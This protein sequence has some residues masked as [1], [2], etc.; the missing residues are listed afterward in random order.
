MADFKLYYDAY[1]YGPYEYEYDYSYVKVRFTNDPSNPTEEAGHTWTEW[2]PTSYQNYPDNQFIR[3]EIVGDLLYLPEDSTGIFRKL[4]A[5]DGSKIAITHYNDRRTGWFDTL[6]VDLSNVRTDYVKNLSYAFYGAQ[7]WEISGLEEWY[8]ENVED[9]S[10]MFAKMPNGVPC[11]KSSTLTPLPQPKGKC[12]WTVLWGSSVDCCFAQYDSEDV[13]WD[14][15]YK[16][17]HRISNTSHWVMPKLK[18]MEG[19]FD[20]SY[21]I[22]YD[23]IKQMKTWKIGPCSNFSRAFA[24]AGQKVFTKEGSDKLDIDLSN[25]IAAT[26]DVNCKQMFYRLNNY[27]TISLPKTFSNPQIFSDVDSMFFNNLNISNIYVDGD[28]DWSENQTILDTT[29]GYQMFYNCKSISTFDNTKT[30]VFKANTTDGY[31]NTINVYDLAD[32]Y[33]RLPS[34]WRVSTPYIKTEDGWKESEVYW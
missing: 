19:L 24:L 10:Y 21:N 17:V 6:K 12:W 20:G 8:M 32:A 22:D 18:T 31:F 7:V 29:N 16:Y 34:G 25:W 28:T 14:T 30:N 23:V 9:I 4:W 13:K 33:I 26:S 1:E 2:T 5:D 27:G 11:Y 15:G 3:Y